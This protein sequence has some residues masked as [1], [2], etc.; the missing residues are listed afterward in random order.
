VVAIEADFQAGTVGSI[1]PATITQLKAMTVAEYNAWFT[2]NFTNAAQALVLL[3]RI[4]LLIIRRL[5]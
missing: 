4:T 1:Q 5:L 3:R 2:A